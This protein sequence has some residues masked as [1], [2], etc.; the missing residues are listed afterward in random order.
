MGL[1]ATTETARQFWRVSEP[2]DKTDRQVWGA[3][4]RALRQRSGKTLYEAAS[5][6]EPEGYTPGDPSKGLSV[7]RW[8]QIEKGDLK[9]TDE[10][11]RRLARSLGA[12][13]EELELERAR[14]L[15]HRRTTRSEGVAERGAVFTLPIWGRTEFGK[16]G[17]KVTG[18]EISEAAFDLRELTGPSIGVTYMPD[19][20]M[21]P[22]V[23]AGR[24]VLFDRARRP[25]TDKGCVVETQAGELYV[26]LFAGDDAEHVMV[27]SLAKPTPTPFKRSEIRGVYAVRF[28]GE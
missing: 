1:L 12:D 10:Q 27:R 8:Q 9:F 16:D 2:P 24:P 4:L 18:A 6:Y 20:A 17:W 15:G 11:R 25:E 13:L 3:A 28:W 23:G 14:I 5:T 26:R 21:A 22:K 7:Q 19:D